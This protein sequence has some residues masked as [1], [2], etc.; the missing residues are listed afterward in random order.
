MYVIYLYIKQLFS[1]LNYIYRKSDK[2]T[3]QEKAFLCG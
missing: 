1:T 2:K 3:K